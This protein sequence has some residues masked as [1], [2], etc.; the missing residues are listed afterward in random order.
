MEI[1]YITGRTVFPKHRGTISIRELRKYLAAE[2]EMQM[3]IRINE[4]M[5]VVQKL[6]EENIFIMTEKRGNIRTSVS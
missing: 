6:N 5:P 4:E 3:P 1:G 2:G